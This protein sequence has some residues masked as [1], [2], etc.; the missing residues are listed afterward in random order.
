MLKVAYTQTGL[1]LEYLTQPI[2]T[3]I[4]S[5]VVLAL[6]TS[7]RLVIECS[8]ASILFP[9]DLTTR[10]DLDAIAQQEP[11]GTLVISVCDAEYV[12]V[13]LRGTWLA[14]DSS[15]GLE[16]TFVSTLKPETERV[17]FQLWQESQT[18]M[19]PLWR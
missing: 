12:E 18:Q 8:F 13:S 2:E 11:T 15:D 3:W 1:H 17:L 5:R 4:A 7:Q 16:G 14:I 19:F 9:A 10:S 6:R